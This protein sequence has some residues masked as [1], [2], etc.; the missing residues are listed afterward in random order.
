MKTKE[1]QDFIDFAK[2]IRNYYGQDKNGKKLNQ[3]DFVKLL[4]QSICSA[5][6]DSCISDNPETLSSYM[7]KRSIYPKASAAL[8]A[9]VDK[10][11]FIRW[12]ENGSAT[13]G[14]LK[15]LLKNLR[16]FVGSRP[17]FQADKKDL[18]ARCGPDTAGE[19]IAGVFIAILAGPDPPA[20]DNAGAG[21]KICT[22]Y[23]TAHSKR[24]VQC[25]VGRTTELEDIQK[26]LDTGA[27]PTAVWVRGMGGLGKTQLCRKLFSDLD[28]RF[29][30][31]GW[32]AFDGDF[33]HS[34]VN[35]LFIDID[36]S[37]LEQAYNEILEYINGKGKELVLFI[38]NVSRSA[39]VDEEL[40]KLT[41]NVVVTSRDAHLEAFAP[42]ELG[43]LSLSEC[44][45]LFYAYYKKKKDGSVNEVIHRAGYL[46]LAVE[47][48]AKTAR[49]RDITVAALLRD[50]IGKSFDLRT[51]VY[52]NW[53]NDE[54][55]QNEAISR[56]FQIV[57]SLSGIMGDEEKMYVLKNMA[58]LPY[59][60]TRQALLCEWLGLDSEN[61]AIHGLYEFGWL[62]YSEDYEGYLMHPIISYTVR[63]DLQ[64]TFM[65]CARLLTA[66]I[67]S[68][69]FTEMGSVFDVLE[70][71][72]Y[73]QEI[74][75][76]FQ[77]ET[78]H[79]SVMALLNIRLANVFRANGEY[80][81]AWQYGQNAEHFAVSDENI[82]KNLASLVYNLLAEICTDM[83]DRDSEGIRYAELAVDASEKSGDPD[84][85]LLSSAYH[86]LAGLLAQQ[87]KDFDRAKETALKAIEIRKGLHFDGDI[88]LA[89]TYRTMAFILRNSG[90]TD[91]AREYME[92][93]IPIMENV[94]ADNPNQPSL[95]V[96][97]NNYARILCG[98][99]GHLDDA[100]HYYKKAIA[101]RETNNPDDPRLA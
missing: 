85:L 82:D 51:A 21:Q 62:Q 11:K 41:C 22:E 80:N 50:L 83:R 9:S 99:E 37:D 79:P 64:P 97:Y 52:T 98:M 86:N 91:G 94:Y 84:P 6:I 19:F 31:L 24:A 13:T 48:L 34:L 23:I 47:L 90:D 72:P 16:D 15:A 93:C 66:F 77:S 4:F 101:I 92:R 44:K 10:R 32:V 39:F 17:R 81:A 25:F 73:A 69:E 56:Q 27:E 59:L 5:D 1:F 60:A 45:D 89:N 88:H 3:P 75:A 20:Q 28:G 53:D 14:A 18:L 38:D 74:A 33:K 35:Q 67:D 87:G 76:Y 29:P 26:M 100:I 65:E 12:I 71:A 78:N 57:F 49:K 96:T 43:F 70:F 2:I 95:A 7:S 42:Y 61:N 58:V 30:F 36:K 46:T 63:T 68:I 54:K 55:A 40:E 8:L